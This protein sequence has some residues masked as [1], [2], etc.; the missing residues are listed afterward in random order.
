MADG[1]MLAGGCLCGA[2][3]YRLNGPL[4]F[5]SQ[6]CCRDCQKATG[7][8]HTTICGIERKD[9]ILDGEPATFTNAGDT[10]GDV[11]RHFCG[12]CGGRLFTSGTLPGSVVM[13]QAGSLDTPDAVTP[14][15][16]IYHKD[17]VAWDRFD[18]ALPVFEEMSPRAN[19]PAL[20]SLK[21]QADAL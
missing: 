6:C 10:G 13:I 16:V 20:R 3:R 8:G 17:A 5:V 7:T 9:V 2:I 4:L 1:E 14:E 19:H 15:S 21:A 11:T 18:P 12:T